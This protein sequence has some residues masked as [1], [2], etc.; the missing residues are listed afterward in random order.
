M[1]NPTQ[2][3]SNYQVWRIAPGDPTCVFAP[4]VAKPIKCGSQKAATLIVEAVNA[5]CR[6][7]KGTRRIATGT[8]GETIPCD[9][10]PDSETRTGHSCDCGHS[11]M[12]LKD[13]APWCLL[14]PPEV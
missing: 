8:P 4:G 6:A 9:C 12:P 11:G 1:S 14:Q 10:S 3:P 5:Y 2:L 7:C 13:H